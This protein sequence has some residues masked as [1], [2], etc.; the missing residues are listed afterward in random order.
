MLNDLDLNKIH[1]F[2]VIFK[3]RG[4]NKAAKSLHI[5]PAAVS[6]T[7]K[8]LEGSLNCQLFVRSNRQIIP[9]SSG[10]KLFSETHHLFSKL[11]ESLISLKSET[12]SIS[13]F[14][15]VGAPQDFASKRLL[16]A[17]CHMQEKYPA[18]KF[19][20]DFG[21]PEK[22]VPLLIQ[23]DLDLLFVDE[24]PFLERY[25]SQLKTEKVAEETLILACSK[26]FYELNNLTLSPSLKILT[27]LPHVL[28][29]VGGQET[30]FYYG[31]HF[32]KNISYFKSSI[33]IDSV[34]CV[35]MAVSQN[36]GLGLLPKHLVQHQLDKGQLIELHPDKK[37][38]KHSILFSIPASKKL[39]RAEDILLT[40]IKE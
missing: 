37:P 19:S 6:Q 25:K 30:N 17:A 22:I 10:E 34:H 12:D 33:I 35:I 40:L 8:A 24:S 5:T 11:E 7:L 38:L 18:V 15:R 16:S 1:A 32:K 20:I 26:T 13:G 27:E 9:T 23:G 2:L 31:H 3:E 28:Y 21:A 14:I 4:I 39:T 29:T 36:A